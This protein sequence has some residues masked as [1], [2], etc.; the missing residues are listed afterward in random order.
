MTN[1]I[2][3]A[4][5][6]KA[7][8]YKQYPEGTS[9]VSSYIEPRGGQ[10]DKAL[11]FG[12]QMFIKSYLTT[13]LTHQ[14]INEAKEVLEAHGVPFNEAGWRHIV[15]THQGFLPIK[16]QALPEG[17]VVPISNALV[18][19]INTDPKC[20]WLTSYVETAL[21]RAIWYPT[22]VATV[23]YHC[24]CIIKR[25]LGET[26]DSLDGLEFKL[27]DFGARGATTEEAAAIGG[28][29]H[30]L[31]FMGTDTLSAIMAARRNY[32]ATMPGFS[33]PAAEHS[34]ITAW[35]RSGE[36]AA[37]E[38]MLKQFSGPGKL[39]AV[40]SD[41]YDLWH[42]ID[43]IWGEELKSLVE[44]SGGTL[45]IRPDSGEPVEVVTTTIEKLMD[46]FGYHTNSKGYRVLPNCVRVIQGDGIA[47]NA[48]EEILSAMKAKQQSAENIA[49]GMGGA[50]L[51]KLDRDTM[52]FAMKA[53]AVKVK[54]LWHDVFKDPVTDHGK[55][56]KKGRLAVVHDP[57]KG[58]KT[59]RENDLGGRENLLKTVFKNGQLLIEQS[60]DEIKA[61]IS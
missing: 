52:Q 55:R 37:Y 61:N 11:F 39:V 10:Y 40:V 50:L 44:N 17:T 24:K 26:A 18:Q 8:H 48:I 31:N 54:G 1:I 6:Y 60:F 29:A 27:H 20:A 12:L 22:T 59:V 36:K 41:S 32:A 45:V 28:A 33:I 53:S 57:V 38:N 16:I 49:F 19:V 14:D 3:N 34:T 42:A 30:L 46:K 4:D 21:L 56:S 58:I 13:P 51:Q 9:Q 35:G 2:L 23:S 43:H 7:S 25:Y 5:S 47:E 15:D